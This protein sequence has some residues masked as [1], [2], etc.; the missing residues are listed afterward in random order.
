TAARL[1][2]SLNKVLGAGSAQALDAVSVKVQAPSDPATRVAF[3]GTLQEV[4]LAPDEAPAR[5][6]VNSRTGTIV[7]SSQ[8]RVSAAAVAH[9]SLSVTITE[10]QDVSQP[11][12]LSSGTTVVTPRSEIA[13]N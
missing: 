4:E 13:V 1:T 12:P 3:I 6:I 10:R 7:I 5:V 8:V 2:E 9:G 11:A